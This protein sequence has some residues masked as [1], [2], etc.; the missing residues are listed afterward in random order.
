MCC[1][2]TFP[3]DLV[4]SCAGLLKCCWWNTE[5][6]SWWSPTKPNLFSAWL[7]RAIL[8][9]S[10]MTIFSKQLTILILALH[11]T[12]IYLEFNFVLHISNHNAYV[13]VIMEYYSYN[14]NICWFQ[15]SLRGRAP[16]DGSE[17]NNRVQNRPQFYIQCKFKT[18]FLR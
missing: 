14:G 4:V 13:Y 10:V 16:P 15:M 11:E 5:K 7:Q 12:L 8:V 17:R 1:Y 18:V 2:S 6:Q 9:N 3:S